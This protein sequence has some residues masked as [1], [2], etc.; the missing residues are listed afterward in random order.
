MSS[1]H[2]THECDDASTPRRVNFVRASEV[3][4]RRTLQGSV[5]LAPTANEPVI[6]NESSSFVWEALR[7]PTSAAAL[8]S[9]ASVAFDGDPSLIETDIGNL[10]QCLLEAHLIATCP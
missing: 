8:T 9:S 2:V 6:M 3:L 7:K 1:S 5:A 4:W 10:L